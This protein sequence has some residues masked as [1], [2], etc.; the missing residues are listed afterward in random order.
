MSERSQN[1]SD[2][3]INPVVFYGSA[4]VIVVFALWVM[5][6]TGPANAV[7]GTVLGWISN[8]FGWFYFVAVVLYLA[9]VIAV[10]V[11]RFGKIR[12]GPEHSR[13]EFPL[14]SWAAM[15]FAAGI[16]IDLLFFCVAEPLAQFLAPPVGEPGTEGAARHAME[17]TLFHWGLSGWGIYTLVGMSLAFF[18]YRHGL[19]LTIRSAL[20]P[21]FGRRIDGWVGHSVDIAAVLG[22]I[23]GIATS[24]GIGI[25]QLNFGLDYMFGIP[26]GQLTQS[27]LAILIVVFAAL[28]AASG[29][30]RGIRR[31]SEFNMLL[32]IVLMLFVLF[33]GET[34]FLLNALVMNLGDYVAHFVALSFNTYAFDPPSDWLNAWTVFFWAWWIAWGPFVGLFLARISRGRTIAEFVGGTLILPF[35]FMVAWMCIMGNSSID[36]V[37]EGAVEF[38]E[39]GM[40]NPGSAIYLFLEQMPWATMTTI[41]ATVLAIVFFVTS[42]DSGS[43][44]LSNFTSILSHADHDAPV[45]MRVLWAAIIGVLTLALLFADGLTALQSTTVIMGLPF[46]IVLILMMIGLFR[47]LRVEVMKSDSR[48]RSLPAYLSSRTGGRQTDEDWTRRIARV[49]SFPTRKEAFAFLT[50]VGKPAMEAIRKSLEEK[51]LSAKIAEGDEP[52]PYLALSVALPGAQ[53]FSYQ[54]RPQRLP[55]PTFAIRPQERGGSYYRAEVHLFEGGQDYDVMGYTKEQLID[56]ILDQYEQHQQFLHMQQKVDDTTEMPDES[57]AD[58]GRPG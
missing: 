26:Q 30:E 50:E 23:F 4:V 2:H 38:G 7:I 42:G 36:L 32:A 17:L 21:I 6:A 11:S 52:E 14:L 47:A 3:R 25:I 24:L 19:P 48:A 15:L 28:S 31:L 55:M 37:M 29:V 35:T 41:A 13:P 16:G 5:V 1:A 58:A 18:S 45:W 44:V 57:T 51:G 33:A 54:I 56:D 20:F 40:N 53:D 9:F 49:L 8:S 43:L 12:L 22:T 34:V 27:V 39:Q 46:S 10:G